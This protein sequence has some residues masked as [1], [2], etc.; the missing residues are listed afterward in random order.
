MCSLEHTAQVI[1]PDICW[2]WSV[3]IILCKVNIGFQSFPVISD[4]QSFLHVRV[5]YCFMLKS[6]NIT[7]SHCI[8]MK[9][10]TKRAIA[11][12]RTR[13][14]YGRSYRKKVM[15]PRNAVFLKIL[16]MCWYFTSISA[17]TNL[18]WE[19]STGITQYFEFLVFY[20]LFV[21]TCNKEKKIHKKLCFGSPYYSKNNYFYNNYLNSSGF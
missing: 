5:L 17:D 15:C 11:V 4:S 6:T 1:I 21:S 18:M 12:C 7:Y 19:F 20:G 13:Q 8:V 16:S 2:S 3:V 9:Q 14:N 10:V